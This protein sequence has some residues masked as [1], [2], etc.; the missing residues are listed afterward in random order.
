M[1]AIDEDIKTGNFKQLYLLYGTEGYLKKQYRDKLKNALAAEGDSMNFS[2]YQGKDINP[3]EV[4]DLAET[5]PFFAERRVILIENSGFFK[6]TCEELA[7]YLPQMAPDTYMIFVEEEIDKR[8]K[9]YKAAKN[10]GHLVEF[11]TQS[12]E[13]LTR[14]IFSRLKKEGRNITGAVMQLFLSKTGTDMGN[15]DRE[16]EK[17][18][19]YTMGRDV[20]TAED[21][22]A[23]VTEQIANKI[24]DMVNAIADHDQR[25]ALELYYDL[26]ALKEPPMRILYLVLRQFSILFHIR[27]MTRCGLDKQTMAKKAGIPP[28][29]VSRNVAQAKGFSVLQLKEAL[30]YGAK[31]EEAVK[32]GQMNDQMAVEL[33][34]V[35]YSKKPA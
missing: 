18:I 22:N 6:N 15:I 25:K 20:V 26:L 7:E 17:L 8:S 3:R 33:F 27:D 35:R 32:T 11:S 5:L 10:V 23:I 30:C 9:T 24:F 21:V 34:L 12:E 4:I 1:R 29:A 13:L 31:L 28:F 19:C 2:A 14:W 16:L